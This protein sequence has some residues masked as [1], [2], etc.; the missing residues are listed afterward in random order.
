M[1]VE[2][3][4]LHLSRLASGLH[5]HLRGGKERAGGSTARGTAATHIY[6][7]AYAV[8]LYFPLF[9]FA[10]YARAPFRGSLRSP[11]SANANIPF[12]VLKDMSPAPVMLA[13]LISSIGSSSLRERV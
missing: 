7:L 8:Y 10:Y 3:R 4:P 6:R 1:G 9:S 13:S 2:S 5:A 11:P 12:L